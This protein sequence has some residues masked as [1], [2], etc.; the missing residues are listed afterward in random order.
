MEFT[1]KDGNTVK[2]T[3]REQELIGKA[4]MCCKD[5]QIDWQRF[6]ASA[7]YKN[8]GA[9][10]SSFGPT[11]KKLREL[12]KEEPVLA[13]GTT[14]S[15]AA[16]VKGRKRKADADAD[17]EDNKSG[18]DNV[19]AATADVAQP[20]K[21]ARGRPKKQVKEETKE[22]V[23]PQVAPQ[24]IYDDSDEEDPNDPVTQIQKQLEQEMKD[25]HV[26]YPTWDEL[27]GY[28]GNGGHV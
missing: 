20:V 14:A 1:T 24:T 23:K 7:G 6:T 27:I 17:A 10:R 22:E 15:K 2:F 16:S 18:G 3:P 28:G 12:Q 21:K 11:M 13:S 25:E 4:F 19:D 9:A 8:V 5:P 26:R